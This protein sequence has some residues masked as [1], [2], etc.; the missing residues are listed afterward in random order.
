MLVKV[1]CGTIHEGEGFYFIM[2]RMN[3]IQLHALLKKS[4]RVKV[5]RLQF[6]TDE[7]D[8]HTSFLYRYPKA[9]RFMNVIMQ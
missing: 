3:I 8:F 7:F 2:K 4:T 6:K 1:S 5:F 9:P